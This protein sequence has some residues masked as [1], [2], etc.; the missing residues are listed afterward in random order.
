MLLP[1]ELNSKLKKLPKNVL[2]RG[3]KNI[4]VIKMQ[5]FFLKVDNYRIIK[6][7]PKIFLQRWVLFWQK[8]FGIKKMV[9][10]I[11]KMSVLIYQGNCSKTTFFQNYFLKN[12]FEF[13]E[14]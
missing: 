4:N 12:A 8:H 14:K 9:T 1:S 13:L 2:F 11:F 7:Q 3:S 5:N 6:K 10:Y